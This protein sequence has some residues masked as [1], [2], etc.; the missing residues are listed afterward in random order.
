[1]PILAPKHYLHKHAGFLGSIC[2]AISQTQ[3][4]ENLP[5]LTLIINQY[6][7]QVVNWL[8]TP[9]ALQWDFLFLKY[10]LIC[11]GPC[12][13][14]V[15]FNSS[16]IAFLIQLLPHSTIPSPLSSYCNLLTTHLCS[17]YGCI[18]PGLNWDSINVS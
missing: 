4:N 12:P 1:M 8:V 2:P 16:Q 7:H 5:H 18:V 11:L 15:L 9:F 6:H 13:N 3:D 10:L 17:F 14:C